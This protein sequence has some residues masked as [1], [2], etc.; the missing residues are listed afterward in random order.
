MQK[1]EGPH[2]PILQVDGALQ[3]DK[4]SYSFVSD[5]GEED[6]EYALTQIFPSVDVRLV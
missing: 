4:L 3:D 2:S 6:A 5:Y 1:E